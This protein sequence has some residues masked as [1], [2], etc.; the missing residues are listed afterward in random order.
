MKNILL[1]GAGKSSTVL[2]DYLKK[3]TT[4]RNW[5]A[6]I[7]DA[8][9][10]QVTAKTNNHKH[11][12]AVEIDIN[13]AS[14]RGELIKQADIVISLMPPSLH[15]LIAK[16]CITF[17]KNLLTASYIDES[18]KALAKDIE[19]NDVLF[20]YEMGLDPGIDH[21]S[22]MQLIHKLK[23]NGEIITKFMSHCGGLVAKESDDNPFHYKISWNPRNVIMAGKEGATFMDSY[24][25]IHLSYEEL[26]AKLHKVITPTSEEFGFYPNRDSLSYINLY[27][28]PTVSQFIRTT[29]R[30]PDFLIG[31]KNILYYKLTDEKKIYQTDGMSL[32]QFFKAHIKVIGLVD[33]IDHLM[34]EKMQEID[35]NMNNLMSK[36][37]YN[38]TTKEME[39]TFVDDEG[40]LLTLNKEGIEQYALKSLIT[41]K[42]DSFKIKLE[43]LRYLGIADD[44]TFINKGL[45][46]AADVLQFILETKLSLLPKDKDRVV[47]L[48]EIETNKDGIIKEYKSLLDLNGEDNINTAMAKTV[49]LPLGIAATLI[50]DGII[51]TKGLQI[52][53]VPEI[54]NPVLTT[55]E[56]EGVVFKEFEQEKKK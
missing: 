39:V 12:N 37:E 32:E 53:I 4:E 42:N 1:F 35:I 6:T 3:I 9:H 22:A 36:M 5:T 2:I 33:W 41:S 20:L 46:S 7:A 18:T 10:H 11:L 16:D 21:M 51:K 50:L 27:D 49:G 45:C 14:K 25:L 19:A 55:L 43:Q 29:L 52:P 17:K 28:V 40:V 13:D 47:M 31:W 34:K 24:Q 8:N 26:F 56:A 54:Y 30:H 38:E 23:A 15:I 44:E 48:H